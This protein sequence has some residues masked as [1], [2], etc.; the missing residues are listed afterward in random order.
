MLPV[1]NSV[2]AV[3]GVIKAVLAIEKQPTAPLPS[4]KKIFPFRSS[5]KIKFP[6]R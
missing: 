5:G 2:W 6:A 4:K 3:L 1:L